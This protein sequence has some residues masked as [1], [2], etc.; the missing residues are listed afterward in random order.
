MRTHTISFRLDDDELDILR[1][2]ADKAGAS[3][4]SYVRCIVLTGKPPATTTFLLKDKLAT[5]AY[6]KRL[7]DDQL[8]VLLDHNEEETALMARAELDYRDEAYARLQE[9]TKVTLDPVERP[10]QRVR[11]RRMAAHSE[12]S[13]PRHLQVN[14]P[15]ARGLAR[16]LATLT[17]DQLLDRFTSIDKVIAEAA[18]K[19]Y[20]RRARGI[21]LFR[22]PRSRRRATSS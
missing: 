3:I 16:Y 19:E 2:R 11:R 7:S 22:K 8:R 21:H 1:T 6:M 13:I 15:E 14:N 20:E 17:D 12:P 18:Q 5:P 10:P 9:K 4:A